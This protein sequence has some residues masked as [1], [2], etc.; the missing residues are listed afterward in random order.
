M[1]WRD[2]DYARWTEA[3]RRRFLGS[4]PSFPAG[5]SYSAAPRQARLFRTGPRLRT[6]PA[7]SVAVLAS[8]ALVVFLGQLPRSHPLVPV[9]HFTTSGHAASSTDTI[10]LPSSLP[11]GSYLTLHGQVPT[12]ETGLVTIEGA[13]AQ[14]PWQ[15]LATVPVTDGSYQAQILL[16][17]P[18][19][20]QLRTT[21]PDGHRSLGDVRVG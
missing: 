20:L 4:G 1:G 7:A 10:S 12:G 2:R 21:L 5:R 3:E 8:L 14:G 16:N 9:L 18:G 17:Q 15:L 19:A 11:L 6:A 13:Y